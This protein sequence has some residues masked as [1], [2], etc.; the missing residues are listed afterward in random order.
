VVY[1]SCFCKILIKNKQYMAFLLL[2]VRYG[3]KVCRELPTN[4]GKFN[5][6]NG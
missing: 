3:V 6:T 5:Q 2:K 1:F 4:Y